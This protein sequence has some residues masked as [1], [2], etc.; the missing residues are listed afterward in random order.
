[1]IN[2]VILEFMSSLLN[3][4]AS[5]S[6]IPSASG[7]GGKHFLVDMQNAL[8]TFTN[9]SSFAASMRD[10]RISFLRSSLKPAGI[11]KSY[12]N[13]NNKS[14]IHYKSGEATGSR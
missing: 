9:K 8:H 12:M 14:F 7:D 3:S 2:P 4:S 10:A 1:M 5:K 13:I 6:A 11:R